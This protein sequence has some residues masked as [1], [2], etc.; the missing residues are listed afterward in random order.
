V[1]G[2]TGA[3]KST[4]LSLAPRLYDP[5]HG[6]VTLAGIDLRAMTLEE[7]RSSVTVVTQRPLLFTETLR[8]NLL[9]GCPDASRTEIELACR[10][11]G[12]ST[13]LDLLP[14]GLDTII[15]ERGINLSG[16]QRQ[17]VTLARALLSPAPVAVLDD[18]LSAVDT[19]A[20][21]EIVE[22]LRLG[23]HG[24]AVLLATQRLSTLALADRIVVLESG[25]I[26]EHGD[27]CQL[28]DDG[29]AFTE[30]FGEEAATRAE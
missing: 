7:V 26:V 17:R 20:E 22:G 8:E 15:G 29:G 13:F 14:N 27:L 2:R 28:L 9:A 21:R 16:G 30:L 5:S 6:A 4:L 10:R 3:G 24:R 1:C 12:V 19:E 23:L 25:R 11:A 18:P